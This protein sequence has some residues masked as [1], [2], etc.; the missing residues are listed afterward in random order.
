MPRRVR[1]YDPN[2]A[3]LHDEGRAYGLTEIEAF[4]LRQL[5]D[6]KRFQDKESTIRRRQFHKRYESTTSKDEIKQLPDT[7]LAADEEGEE[8]WRNAEGDRLADFGV[9]EEA[10]FY[11]DENVPLAELMRRRKQG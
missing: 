8:A 1:E 7:D 4:R 6:L 3:F 2:N 9:D 11:D 5:E 10:E